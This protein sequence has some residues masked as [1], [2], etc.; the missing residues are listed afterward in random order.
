MR[1]PPPKPVFTFANGV[2][3]TLERV[4]PLIAAEIQA[5]HPAPSPPLAPGVGGAMEPN[6][7]D[8][9]YDSTLAA[10]TNQLAMLIMDAYFD[11]GV[12]DDI[13]IDETAVARMRSYQARRGK[14]ITN[15][16]DKVVYIKYVLVTDGNDLPDLLMAIQRYDAPQEGQIAA[17]EATFRR[18]VP[19]DGS[20]HPATPALRSALQSHLGATARGEV[21]GLPLLPRVGGPDEH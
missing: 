1:M 16:T 17:A 9:L 11:L 7:A 6:P 21:G 4:G 3:V 15:L 5:E 14:D 13:E 12:S 20:A 19:G 2:A 10:H 8:P 18:D